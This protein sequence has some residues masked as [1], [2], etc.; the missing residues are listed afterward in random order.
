MI[1]VAA[2]A[3]LALPA[4]ASAQQ[5]TPEDRRNAAREC[6]ALQNAM[7][8]ENFRNTYGTNR[9]DRNA[10]GK[11]VSSR[12]RDEAQEGQQARRNAAQQCR[13]ERDDPNFA[14]SHNG[15][16]FAE[17]YGTNGNDRN[18]FGRCVSMRARQN[19]Q[20]ADAEDRDRVNAARAC[21]AE[22][23]DP[24]FPQGHDGKSFAEFYGTNRGNRNA[25]G[26]CVSRKAQEQEQQEQQPPT[27]S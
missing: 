4:A 10:F 11:C 5:P 25:F 7:G 15:Q 19:E 3:T 12:A 17:F 26:K 18:A 24:N 23:R 27:Q 8:T 14:Q 1:A 2:L 6:R 22:Q 16:S 20:E 21:R 13:A 9:N